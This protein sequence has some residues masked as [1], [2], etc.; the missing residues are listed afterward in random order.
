M[1][2]RARP[3]VLSLNYN[4]YAVSITVVPSTALYSSLNGLVIDTIRNTINTV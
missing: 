4:C 1:L 2:L 3:V